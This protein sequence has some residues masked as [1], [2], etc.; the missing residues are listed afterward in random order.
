MRTA[1]K[2]TATKSAFS[3]HNK[4]K[5]K[6]RAAA[7]DKRRELHLVGKAPDPAPDES[8]VR[9]DTANQPP[10]EPTTES[11][12][13]EYTPAEREAINQANNAFALIIEAVETTEDIESWIP[14]LVRGVRALRDRAKRE[15][16]ALNYLDHQYRNR[17]SD[18]LNAEPIGP[19]LLDP[20]RRSLLDAVHYLGS[21][22]TYL[23]AFLEW[24]RTKI[25]DEDRRKWRSLR[26]MVD[27]FRTWQSG[28][29]PNRDRRSP[30]QKEIERV[31]SEGHKADLAREAEIEQ[32][33]QELTTG[34]IESTTTF[35][36]LLRQAGPEKFAQTLK[37]NDA[38]DYAR[39]VQR[40]LA[41][42]LKE[43]AT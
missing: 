39:T 7:T 12:V 25:T 14:P 29:V 10:I 1:T 6:S 4:T 17:F 33:R 8:S 11:V 13:C 22:D 19:W 20:A 5:K 37:D 2:I 40:L 21:D 18:L 41:I 36:T 42:W 26:V 38:K 30:D 31:R 27:H 3:G 43:P 32:T 34:T 23:D 16:G 35:W 15:T 24:R 28:I 9:R